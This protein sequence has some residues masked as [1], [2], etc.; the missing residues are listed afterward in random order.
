MHMESTPEHEWLKQLIGEWEY[1]HKWITGES[2]ETMTSK[3]REVFRPFGD[4][5]VIG[6][7]T[8]TMPGGSEMTALTTL[9]F[10]PVK[11]K[12][13]GN[14][15]GTPMTHMFI[16]EGERNADNTVLTLNCSGPSFEDVSEMADYQDIM[17][18]KSP[19]ERLFFSQY[20]DNEGNW[21]RFME[22]VLRRTK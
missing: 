2:D 17:E 9:G 11:G 20:K 15:I 5:W 7:L 10:D 6:E 22:G 8:G 4:L 3:G 16:Y 21:Q 18:F 12:F 13:I 19:E 1:E 14:W